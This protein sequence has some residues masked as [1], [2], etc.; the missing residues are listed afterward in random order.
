MR[1]METEDGN[2]YEKMMAH[3]VH[4]LGARR[5]HR[6]HSFDERETPHAEEVASLA[7]PFLLSGLKKKAAGRDRGG[8][9]KSALIGSREECGDAG[10]SA[11][12]VQQRLGQDLPLEEAFANFGARQ[13]DCE[14]GFTLVGDGDMLL[15]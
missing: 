1:Q 12:L 3:D 4:D 11:R 5:K 14:S 13:Q 8:C 15:Y 6:R 2:Q 9:L 7:T 10:S